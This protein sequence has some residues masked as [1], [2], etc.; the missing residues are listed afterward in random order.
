M[1]QQQPSVTRTQTVTTGALHHPEFA[2][3][4][5]FTDDIIEYI[6][7]YLLNEVIAADGK[8][9]EQ[10]KDINKNL[11]RPLMKEEYVY[12]LVSHLRITI[13]R[14]VP[15]SRLE[16][17]EINNM[18]EFTANDLDT[19]FAM[20][21]K[22]AGISRGMYFSDL[23]SDSLINLIEA[24]MKMPQDGSIQ[25]FFK[26]TYRGSES[27]GQQNQQKNPIF[28]SFLQKIGGSQ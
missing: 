10:R 16:K 3:T 24:V 4:V 22:K 18:I 9:W 25:D 19:W 7:H 21:W 1:D 17:N 23:I 14:F 28:P 2:K 6:R 27:I 8:T 12:E 15:M 13:T 11:I 26:D 5:I 20:N